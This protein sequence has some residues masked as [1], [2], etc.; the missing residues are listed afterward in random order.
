[1]RRR[2]CPADNSGV[3][4]KTL[5]QT[6]PEQEPREAPAQALWRAEQLRARLR[7]ALCTPSGS[8][9]LRH[10]LRDERERDR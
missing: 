10:W 4:Q 3:S 7:E 2:S 5:Q 9:A 1:M 6:N 8:Q